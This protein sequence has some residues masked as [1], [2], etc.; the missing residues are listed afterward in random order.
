MWRCGDAMCEMYYVR[1]LLKFEELFIYWGVFLG[2]FRESW[3]FSGGSIL[4]EER[5]SALFSMGIDSRYRS[6]VQV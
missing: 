3:W 1:G 6:R 5:R 2:S 4:W